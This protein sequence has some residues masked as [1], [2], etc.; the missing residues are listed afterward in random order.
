[1]KIARHL[2]L[3]GSLLPAVLLGVGCYRSETLRSAGLLTPHEGTRG[4][5]PLAT[6]N[7]WTYA[8]TES[9][10]VYLA[11]G[12]ST[13]FGYSFHGTVQRTIV[14]TCQL[15]G[16][17][18]VIESQHFEYLDRMPRPDTFT[19]WVGYRQDRSGLF[20]VS[21]KDSVPSPPSPRSPEV[22][23][24]RY[25]LHS[26][27][28][29]AWAQNALA[30]RSTVEAMEQLDL[31]PGRFPAWRVRVDRTEGN[32]E[33]EFV[34][35]GVHGYLKSV[36]HMEGDARVGGGL[37]GRFVSE[38]REELIDFRLVRRDR[39]GSECDLAQSTTLQLDRPQASAQLW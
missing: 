15:L 33:Y 35:Y 32:P 17:D 23:V 1:L 24:L 3:V 30:P 38:E 26:G 28:S 27:L 13:T 29:W 11:S 22:T 18:Y 34:W 25:P 37:A 31:P 6:G 39:R 20:T 19:V 16:Q 21:F 12:D 10:K 9:L 7:R 14:G 36:R 5:Y 8:R 2:V 4:F